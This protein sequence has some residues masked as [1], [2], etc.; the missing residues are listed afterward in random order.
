M[1]WQQ[2]FYVAL[3][4]CAFVTS[5]HAQIYRW[6]NGK[7]IPG[8]NGIKPG[9][10][11]KLI[12]W[13]TDSHNLRYADFSAGLDLSNADFHRS[14]LDYAHFQGANLTSAK[15]NDTVLT[16]ANLKG[17]NLTN[18]N[19]Y[20]THLENVNLTGA[21][22]NGTN[23]AEATGWGFKVAQL[24]ST[25]SYASKNLSGIVL[26]YNVL[27]GA[28]LHEQDLTNAHL[29]FA[30]LDGANLTGAVVTGANLDEVTVRGF[31]AA[32]LYSTQSYAAK[33]L[34]GIQLGD[35]NLDGWDF[36][37]QN[38]ANANFNGST[39]ANANLA[40]A[41]LTNA[42]LSVRALTNA[43]LTGAVVTGAN[44][45]FTT[46]QGFTAAQLYSTQSYAAKSLSGIR[47][48]HNN[49]SGWD[50]HGQNLANASLAY[51]TLNNANLAGANLA[52]ARVEIST[53]TN[54]NLTGAD[55]RG[56]WVTDLASAISKN[57]ILS[58][59][60]LNGLN[61]ASGEQLLV[62]NYHGNPDQGFQK[63]PVKINSSLTISTGGLLSLQLD[64]QPWDSIVR[65]QSGIPVQLGGTLELNFT[66]DTQLAAQPGRSIKVF[67]WTGVTPQGQFTV[68]GDGLEWDTSQ[69]YTTGE[70]TLL[71]I[72]S[73]LDTDQDVDSN[74]LTEFLKNW[75][76]SAYPTADKT[77]HD[78][79]S[80]H[81]GDVDSADMLVFL[82]QWTGAAAAEALPAISVPEPSGLAMLCVIIPE[83]MRRVR[84]RSKR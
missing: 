69:L 58:D 9:P 32:Q 34:H 11:V 74:D 61:L 53:L 30:A 17:A 72:S 23:F 52:N 79:D 81:D 55:L 27:S 73:D 84:K 20:N 13:N 18:A 41:N 39:L 25:Q 37:D 64:G 38:L 68:Q 57:V 14:W 16:K 48:E 36:H 77:W 12:N 47:L 54:A 15:L 26:D 80:D 4:L 63:I 2:S 83:L 59:G 56:S 50:F 75:T 67:D 19:L 31:K 45:D 3:V 8:T 1:A 70:V 62:R 22:V 29:Y 43:N 46:S 82:S 6:D 7:L 76:G 28:D 5:A 35:N 49:L 33:D 21:L 42:G 66:D 71:G 10:G 24:Y 60:Q 51:S 40:G 44:F 65:F 78:G